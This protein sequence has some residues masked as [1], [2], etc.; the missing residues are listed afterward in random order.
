MTDRSKKISELPV[1]TSVANN[2]LFII[3]KATGNTSYIIANNLF[4]S[5]ETRFVRGPYDTDAAANTGGV[6]V[7][8]FYYT[9]TGAVKVRLT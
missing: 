5:I 2:D 3:D 6:G 4:N 1:A 8:K 7:G 9:S